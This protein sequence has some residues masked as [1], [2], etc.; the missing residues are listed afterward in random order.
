[1]RTLISSPRIVSFPYRTY[2]IYINLDGVTVEQWESTATI[3]FLLSAEELVEDPE[4]ILDGHEADLVD[5]N[6]SIDNFAQYLWER[7]TEAN[8]P[9]TNPS[10]QHWCFV[11]KSGKVV[12]YW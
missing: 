6:V 4:N 7:P 10:W 11:D 2:T 1:M 3:H 8:I 12:L 9:A 5:L